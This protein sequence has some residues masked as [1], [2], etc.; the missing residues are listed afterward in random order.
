M[1]VRLSEHAWAKCEED[2]TGHA[3]AGRSR[4]WGRWPLADHPDL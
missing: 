3:F 4:S 1:S 2:D